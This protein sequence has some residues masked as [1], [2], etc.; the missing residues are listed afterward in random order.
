MMK[1]DTCP[2]VSHTVKPRVVYNTRV[3][4]PSIEKDSLRYKYID[5]KPR[6]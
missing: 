5:L 4:L 3:F 2:S 6:P 1:S